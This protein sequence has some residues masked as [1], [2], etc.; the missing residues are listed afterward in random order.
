MLKVTINAL[1][2]QKLAS[3]MAVFIKTKINVDAE[4]NRLVCS[5][6]QSDTQDGKNNTDY[7]GLKRGTVVQ[8]NPSLPS[9]ATDLIAMGETIVKN[10]IV[11]LNLPQ[12]V[13]TES[14]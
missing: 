9:K 13:S 2:G 1:Q 11:S 14:I 8:D 12:I 3:P 6:S 7:V 4:N 10:W 5:F